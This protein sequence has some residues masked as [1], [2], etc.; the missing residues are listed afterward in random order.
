MLNPAMREV[1]RMRNLFRKSPS[2]DPAVAAQERTRLARISANSKAQGYA[3][4]LEDLTESLKDCN[5]F[6]LVSIEPAVRRLQ[7][8][9]VLYAEGAGHR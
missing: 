7:R 6:A 5:T 1:K 8:K 3:E 2:S 9:A 4:A